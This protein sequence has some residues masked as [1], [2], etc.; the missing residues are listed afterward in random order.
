MILRVIIAAAA[1][2]VMVAA[3]R[4][5]PLETVLSGTCSA[6]VTYLLVSWRQRPIIEAANRLAQVFCFEN[7]PCTD[8]IRAV[9]KAVLL[10]RR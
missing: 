6:L 3:W 10:W 7:R 1:S 2:F 4:H 9:C 5:A 8:E